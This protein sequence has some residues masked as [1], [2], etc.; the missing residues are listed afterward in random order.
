MRCKEKDLESVFVLSKRVQ[1]GDRTS[2]CLWVMWVCS[3]TRP[4]TSFFL[5]K[6]SCFSIVSHCFGVDCDMAKNE[7]GNF[8]SHSEAVYYKLLISLWYWSGSFQNKQS[9]YYAC[10]FTHCIQIMCSLL[11]I[12]FYIVL[13]IFMLFLGFS[14][15]EVFSSECIAPHYVLYFNL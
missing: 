8:W 1:G 10:C 3:W 12:D 14:L 15:Y 9:F 11:S 5:K 4:V 6:H 7:G 2:P 13:K